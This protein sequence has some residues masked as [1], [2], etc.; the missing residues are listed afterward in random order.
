MSL[1]SETDSGLTLSELLEKKRPPDSVPSEGGGVPLEPAAPPVV[2]ATSRPAAGQVRAAATQA[3]QR[4][5]WEALAP[6]LERPYEMVVRFCRA[7]VRQRCGAP[8]WAIQEFVRGKV[9]DALD[10]GT[11]AGR[12]LLEIADAAIRGIV[13]LLDRMLANGREIKK[14]RLKDVGC[15]VVC[16]EVP[17]YPGVRLFIV[18]RMGSRRQ[19]SVC[20]IRTPGEFNRWLR[21]AFGRRMKP[22][23]RPPPGSLGWSPA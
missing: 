7:V 2:I 11:A 6:R 23:R 12:S 18:L 17:G 8:E 3:V 21:R 16:D 4:F 1:Q 10:T 19:G 14:D 9:D 20:A 13:D 5:G 22:Y 15:S